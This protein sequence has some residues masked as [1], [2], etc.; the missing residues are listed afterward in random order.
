MILESTKSL[1]F[2]ARITVKMLVLIMVFSV[3]GLYWG[4]RAQR[5]S[6]DLNLDILVNQAGYMPRA[7]KTCITKGNTERTFEVIN[8]ETQEVV[9]TGLLE[10]KQGDF[11]EYSTG[12]FTALAREGHYYVRSDT[13]RSYPFQISSAIYRSAMDLMVGYFSFQRCGPSKTGYFSPCHLDD[14]VRLDNGKHQDVTGG[15]HD[16]SDLRKWVSAT[17][18]GMMGLAKTYE[19]QKGQ[20]REKILD[21]LMWGNRYFLK[22][23]EPQGYVM[24]YIGGEVWQNWD[25]NRWTDNEVGPYGGELRLMKPS[26]GKSTNEM[27][28]FGSKDDRIIQTDPVNM[29]GQYNFITSEAIM[30]RITKTKD[31]GYSRKCLRAAEK[32]LDWCAESSKDFDAGMLG[33]AI[34]ASLEMYKTTNLDKYKDIAIDQASQLSKLQHTVPGNGVSGF[35]RTSAADREPYKQIWEGCLGFISVCDLIQTFPTD[36]NVPLWKEMISGY[37][38]QYLSLMSEQNNFGIIPYGLYSSQDPGGNRRT[39]EYWYRY[40]MFPEDWWVGI[41]ANITSAGIGLVKASTILHDPALKALA[42]KQ[43]DWVA[44]VNPF[45][46]ST[47]VGIGYNH[48]ARF[49]NGNEFR[50][51]TPVLPGAVMNGLGGDPNDQPTVGDGDYHISEYWT[52]MVAYTLWLMAELSGSE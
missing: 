29:T 25:N 39:G 36:K 17:L 46:S 16:A 13:L 43:L 40:F 50:P 2:P 42:Q 38:Y 49:V 11:G 37:A 12:D 1:P 7:G 20:A 28:I 52:P 23:Q 14:G 8:L 34:Q 32:C 47:I 48:P 30:A 6:R 51:A 33:A 24:N 4:L 45:G 3:E 9:F 35:F 27:L 5:L 44:G 18:Y 10:P 26:A 31:P 19:L 15:W 21:E 41:N 22:M